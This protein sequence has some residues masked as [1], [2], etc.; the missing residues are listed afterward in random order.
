MFNKFIVI[1]CFQKHPKK[2]S[3]QKMS[4][5]CVVYFVGTLILTNWIYGDPRKIQVLKIKLV[6]LFNIKYK[7]NQ[8]VK[9]D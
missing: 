9:L 5:L 1:Y 7:C 6:Y 3:P 8:A 2:Q 4:Q